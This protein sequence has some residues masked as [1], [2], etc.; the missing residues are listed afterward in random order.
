MANTKQPYMH[1][2]VQLPSGQ[3]IEPGGWRWPTTDKAAFLDE[4]VYIKAA[5]LAEQAKLDG[6]FI[7]DSPGITMDI[8]HQPPHH[9]LDP[10]VL[11]ALMAKATERLGLIPT[12]S[13]SL[14]EPY[15]IARMLRSLD[16]VSKGRM[17]W[18]VVTTNS[19]EAQ[20]NY[21]PGI[22]DHAHKHARSLEVWEAVLRLWGSWPEGALKLDVESG[23]FADT[24]LIQP[25]NFKG[26]YVTTRGPINLPPSP[27]GQPP[28]FTAG[29]GQYGFEFATTRANAMYSNPPTLAYAQSFWKQLAAGIRQ[30]GRNPDE[31]TIF[32]GIG[33]SIASSEQ[34]AL[35]RRA[36]LDELGDPTSRRQ[37]LGHLLGLP[38]LELN[39]DAPI[40]AALLQRAR[41][42]RQDQRAQYAYE[43]AL[44]GFTI[45]EVLAH[46]PINYHPIFLGTPEQ[47]ADK[48][49]HWFEAGVGKGFSVVPDSGLESLTDFVE[50]VVPI[51]QRRGLL[52]TEYSGTTLRE[53]LDLPYQNGLR[54]GHAATL[55]ATR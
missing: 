3:G 9:G 29:G 19:P 10:L 26:E 34:E 6:L 36:A 54:E 5:Q 48:F 43:L 53:H 24:S 30:A 33:V 44:K 27:Q 11:M 49:Q 17:G 8:S 22:L 31:F 38:V 47:I 37:Y 25:I 18:N 41:P 52:R 21:F 12:L 13:T 50:Q 20:L 7:A 14:N 28:V 32:N 15:T 4:D 2:V 40:P 35:K 16:L 23:V 39:Q 55:A 45:R 51:L 46:G 1:L 42:S